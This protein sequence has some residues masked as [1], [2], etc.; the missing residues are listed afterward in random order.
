MERHAL[1]EAALALPDA[2]RTLLAQELLVSLS[3]EQEY[4]AEEDFLA[5]LDRRFDECVSES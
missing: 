2:E 4:V 5:E 3:P 1:F